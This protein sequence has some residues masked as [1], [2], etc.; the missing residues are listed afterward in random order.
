MIVANSSPLIALGR[1]NRLDILEILFGKIH[2]PN[3]VYQETVVETALEDQREAISRSIDAGIVIVVDSTIDYPFKRKLHSGE[4]DVLNLAIEK[5]AGAIII[6]DTRARKEAKELE[7]KSDILYTTDV[8]KGA[9]KRGLI[10]SY[11]DIMEELKTMNIY[12]PEE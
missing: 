3:A 6:D 7:L 12:L 9:E 10:T 1:L 2:I 4:K 8:L 11:T 5:K